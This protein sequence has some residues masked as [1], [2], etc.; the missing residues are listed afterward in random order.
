MDVKL[1]ISS[2]DF[3]LLDEIKK[4]EPFGKANPSPI[5]GDKNVKV[6]RIWFIGKEKNI[7]KF[8]IQSSNH[9]FIDGISFDRGEEFKEMYADKY[10]E[11]KLHEIID[12]SYCDFNMDIV[13]VPSINE[14]NG[15]V[16]VQLMIKGIR[17]V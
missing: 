6:K 4:M 8:R 15:K 2:V 16:S 7:A 5:F 1:G 10:G 9:G 14:F 11:D 3:D 12:S 13:Y 17:L